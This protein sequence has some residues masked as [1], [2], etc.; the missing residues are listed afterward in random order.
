MLCM[1]IGKKGEGIHPY[2]LNQNPILFTSSIKKSK[3][4]ILEIM[5]TYRESGI[6]QCHVDNS[7]H[8]KR[9]KYVET[10]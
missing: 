10:N 3:L 6:A 7:G 2:K 8:D 9:G 5:Y 1:Y 4:K